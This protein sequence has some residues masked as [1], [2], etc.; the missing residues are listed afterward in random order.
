M[1]KGQRRQLLRRKMRKIW[2][3]VSVDIPDR[4]GRAF[5]RVLWGSG[6]CRRSFKKIED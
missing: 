6:I 4:T 1:T 2:K 5:S 3:N